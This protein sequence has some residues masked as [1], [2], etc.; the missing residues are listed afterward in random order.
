MFEVP[1]HHL[2]GLGVPREVLATEPHEISVYELPHPNRKKTEAF[3]RSMLSDM[4]VLLL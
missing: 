1:V 2:I 4:V 3:R